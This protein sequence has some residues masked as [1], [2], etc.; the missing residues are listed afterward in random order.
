MHYSKYE[1]IA[2]D[3]RR[4]FNVYKTFIWRQRRCIDVLEMFRRCPVTTGILVSRQNLRKTSISYPLIRTRTCAYSGSK[5]Y[6]YFGKFCGRTKWII[7][8]VNWIYI[9]IEDLN[10]KP[11]WTNPTKLSNTLKQFVSCCWQIVWVCLTILWGWCL[12]V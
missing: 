6:Q 3:M 10:F 1:I 2:V 7:P 12:K 4:R 5:G 9:G 11:W 8:I